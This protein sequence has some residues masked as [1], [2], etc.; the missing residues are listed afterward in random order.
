MSHF[1]KNKIKSLN[2]MTGRNTK[3]AR[4]KKGLLKAAKI[5]KSCH[6]KTDHVKAARYI[7]V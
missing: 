4:K 3:F 7:P 1:R 2:T 6:D 5:N